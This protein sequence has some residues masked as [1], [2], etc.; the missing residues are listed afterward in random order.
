MTGWLLSHSIELEYWLQS[1]SAFSLAKA[2]VCTL[3]AFMNFVQQ[4]GW[5]WQFDQEVEMHD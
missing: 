5:S 2:A 3:Y 4:L 1:L